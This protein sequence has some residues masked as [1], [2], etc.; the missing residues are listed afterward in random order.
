MGKSPISDFKD[1]IL[2][3]I[4]KKTLT[5]EQAFFDLLAYD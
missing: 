2:N 1:N 5:D 4:G 3:Y